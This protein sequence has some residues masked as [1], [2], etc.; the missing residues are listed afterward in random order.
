MPDHIPAAQ[1][2]KLTQPGEFFDYYSVRPTYSLPPNW[3]SFILTSRHWILE[4]PS[5]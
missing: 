1:I 4:T 2:K 3:R 5:F